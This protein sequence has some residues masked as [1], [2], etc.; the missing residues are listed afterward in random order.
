MP[1][2]RLLLARL[3]ARRFALL[4]LLLLG[5]QAI[6][7]AGFMP[8]FGKDGL[9]ISLCTGH[10]A[11]TLALPEDASPQMLAIARAQQQQQQEDTGKDG[12]PP[13][14][15]AALGGASAL[16]APPPEIPPAAGHD[17]RGDFIVPDVAIGRGLAAPP[18]STGPPILS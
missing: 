12:E 8:A 7:P 10:G 16:A 6:V 13:C 3:R 2:G 11:Q 15:Y 4:A 9:S 18:P 1:A 14:P 5:L 17:A